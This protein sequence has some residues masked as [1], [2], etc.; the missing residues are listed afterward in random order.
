MRVIGLAAAAGLLVACATTPVPSSGA[1]PVPPERVLAPELTKPHQGLAMLVVTRDRGFVMAACEANVFVDGLKVAKLLQAEQ[2]RMFL[3]EGDHLIG[4]SADTGICLGGS[5]QESIK[6]TR[7]KPVLLRI[8]AGN[9][10]GIQI[11][12][13]A[14]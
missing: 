5:D 14:F 10:L 7:A 3:E 13:S 11:Q 2:I 8:T 4:V 9:G 1:K 6:V 12:P